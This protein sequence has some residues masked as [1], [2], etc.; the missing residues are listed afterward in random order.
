MNAVIE[1]FYQAQDQITRRVG[2]AGRVAMTLGAVLGVTGCANLAV[3]NHDFSNCTVALGVPSDSPL[4]VLIP[5]HP[6]TTITPNGAMV[7]TRDPAFYQPHNDCIIGT[8]DNNYGCA[9][10]TPAPLVYDSYQSRPVELARSNGRFQLVH[11][12][13]GKQEVI[14]STDGQVYRIPPA[15]S[16]QRTFDLQFAQANCPRDMTLVFRADALKN[17]TT[18]NQAM[19]CARLPPPSSLN[20]R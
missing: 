7:T 13:V 20:L 14:T 10:T 16:G 5:G 15:T 17:G 9:S 11:F 6:T 8:G 1:K 4:A 3:C 19:S 18:P 2:R 12:Q